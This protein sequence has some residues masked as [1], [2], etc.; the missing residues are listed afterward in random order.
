MR[1]SE[2]SR[3]PPMPDL[4][5]GEV[6]SGSDTWAGK[7]RSLMKLARFEDWQKP[8]FEPLR[9]RLRQ[10]CA[11]EHPD[12][13]SPSDVVIDPE[14]GVF[15]IYAKPAGETAAQRLKREGPFTPEEC[16]PLIEQ[17]LSALDY[18]HG[19]GVFHGTISPARLL[20]CEKNVLILDFLS[21]PWPTR[22][23]AASGDFDFYPTREDDML[24]LASTVSE[25][26]TGLRECSY[27]DLYTRLSSLLTPAQLRRFT[28]FLEKKLFPPM[29][30][31]RGAFESPLL[32]REA[33]KNLRQALG[34]IGR[35]FYG[36][37]ALEILANR[38]TFIF[39]RHLE[40]PD[41]ALFAL[42]DGVILVSTRAA[43]S[44]QPLELAVEIYHQCYHAGLSIEALR[45]DRL[46]IEQ[47]E[48]AFFMQSVVCEE[49][50]RSGSAQ[51][52][53][54]SKAD[55]WHQT[56]LACSR[57]LD[58]DRFHHA[59]R[60]QCRETCAARALRIACRSSHAERFLPQSL[61]EALHVMEQNACA[62]T[63]AAR[64]WWKRLAAGF[65]YDAYESSRNSQSRM[66]ED[67]RLNMS[68]RDPGRSRPGH[69]K[70][71]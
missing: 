57:A 48:A 17:A 1:R 67:L 22:C 26:L 21:V 62:F 38:I 53:P 28:P 36:A 42:K 8:E 7:D 13:H 9:T 52:S 69:K 27:H 32:E 65:D 23:H 29:I 14:N 66:L 61:A 49:I 46:A 47:E 6:F 15:A 3:L 19:R 54:G 33:R 58:L 11:L 35:S 43:V 2:D 16:W 44:A 24:D 60:R 63:R 34:A 71:H 25:M 50:L 70:K 18:A 31:E 59:V 20:V 64:R 45:D 41:E 10:I 68:R 56:L 55:H 40:D 39:C 12:I 51:L 5:P 37:P 4:Q 30:S